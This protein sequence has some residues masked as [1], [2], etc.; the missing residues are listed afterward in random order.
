[1]PVGGTDNINTPWQCTLPAFADWVD[2]RQQAAIEYLEEAN[3]V[4]KGQFLEQ[5]AYSSPFDLAPV[6]EKAGQETLRRP[7]LRERLLTDTRG[8]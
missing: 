2:R 3:M 6:Q 4:L 7:E 1:V 8:W 5:S